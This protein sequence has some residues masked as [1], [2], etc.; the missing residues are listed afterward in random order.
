[1]SETSGDSQPMQDV[2][3]ATSTPAE[4]ATPAATESTPSINFCTL[5]EI[6]KQRP[7]D[8][9]ELI[10]ENPGHLEG[11]IRSAAQASREFNAIKESNTKLSKDLEEALKFKQEANRADIERSTKETLGT[12][13]PPEKIGQVV[14][15][16]T[17]H[18]EHSELSEI[19]ALLAQKKSQPQP[20][21]PRDI[22][23]MMEDFDRTRRSQD[24]LVAAFSDTLL[25]T[26]NK[27]TTVSHSVSG[28]KRQLPVAD[29]T[30]TVPRKLFQI[31]GN[32]DVSQNQTRTNDSFFTQAQRTIEEFF[33]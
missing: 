23:E 17:K 32:G 21:K 6:M 25:S 19:F 10:K 2:P 30:M 22:A 7:A 24:Q 29:S 31:T 11:L 1:M 8:M 16:F 15:F 14:D 28:S 4:T 13:L 20:Q 12:L 33:V 3:A 27:S 5:E 18:P 26:P 9:M